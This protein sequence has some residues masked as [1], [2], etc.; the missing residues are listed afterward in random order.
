MYTDSEL[1]DA[2]VLR[3]YAKGDVA[4]LDELVR[5]HGKALLGFL[6]AMTRDSEAA[7]DLFQET[8]LRVIRKPKGFSE[9]S[10]RAWV[11]RI[12]RNL[13]IDRSRRKQADCSLDAP[14]G[15]E[16]MTLLDV[17][18]GNEPA[19]SELVA[20]MDLE[21]RIAACVGCLPESQREVFL[22]RTQAG[23]SFVEI[24]KLL[25]VPLNTALGRMHYAVVRLRQ[26]LKMLPGGGD[27]T[28]ARKELMR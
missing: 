26:E 2:D 18:P 10:F 6:R 17:L 15:E 9:G 22:L 12:A 16:E 20:G 5:R 4:A 8:W 13:I 21:A 27:L 25:H 24:G 1:S 19:P 11:W 7:E 28:A 3:A 14:V 23:L